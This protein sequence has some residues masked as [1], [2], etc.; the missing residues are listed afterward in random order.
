[1]NNIEEET[2]ILSNFNCNRDIEWNSHL[3][4]GIKDLVCI[5]KKTSKF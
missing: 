3:H 5:K 4:Q 2:L 1:M